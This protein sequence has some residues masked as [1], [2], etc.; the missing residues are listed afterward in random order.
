MTHPHGGSIIGEILAAH[1]VK[2]VYTLCGGHISPI[3]TGAKAHGLSIVDV[4]DEASAAFAA[5]AASRM[6]GIPGVCAVTAGPGVTNTMT[7]VKNAQ[8]AQQP[9]IIFGGATATAL[10]G[11]GSLQD[12]DQMSLMKS[13]TKW[14][15]RVTK[16]N[17]LAPTL[18]R[19]FQVASEGVP[20]PVF[21]EVPVDILYPE[22]IVA[23]WY[24]KE[25]GVDGMK[26][27]VGTVAQTALKGYLK[28]QFHMPHVPVPRLPR[29]TS[30]VASDAD[31]SRAASALSG[32]KK[33][34]VVIGS[35]ALVNMTPEEAADLA[36]AVEA[37]GIPAFLGGSARGLLGHRSTIQFRHKRSRALRE[38]DVVLVA[39]FPFDFRM[40]YGQ[41]IN[42][43]A[44]LISINLDA[45]A[46]KKNRKP[47]QAVLDHPGRFLIWL[48]KRITPTARPDWLATLKEREDARDAE[49]A[50]K[51]VSVG[52]RVDPVHLFLH[53]EEQ[54]DDDS[55]LIVDGGDFVATAAYIVRPRKPLSWLDPGVFGTLGVG[56]GFAVGAA[57]VRP[58]AEI[59]LFYGDG[60]SAYSLA[61]FDSYIRHGYAP[62]AVIGTDAS[63][64]QIAR[65]QITL[66]GDDVGTVL[67]RTAYHTVAEGYGG[68]GF[69]L[70]DPAEIPAVIAEAKRLAA[71]GTPVCI[72][73]HLADSDF[74]EGSISI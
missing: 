33:P 46:L 35:Q 26:G 48:S 4:R 6:T 9:M 12:I 20:G 49:I 34:V 68:K 64:H 23:E 18:E 3:L 43:K 61:E 62:I 32:A 52:P 60:S 41:K 50:A 59:W 22:E 54:L 16:V 51:A 11:R 47:T 57:S 37:M 7:A 17:D 13:V 65:D 39:G 58:D 40:G 27:A 28:H 30:S 10:K 19:A 5:D 45:V 1:G 69:L 36:A 29:H 31:L 53:I 8:M 56:G 71:E 44:N 67:L 73:V 74:R 72:N 55:I 70:T 66:L 63:W 21:I 15:T 38:A 14:C 24:M 2:C 42:K 25:S